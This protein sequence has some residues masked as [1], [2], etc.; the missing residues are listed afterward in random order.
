MVAENSYFVTSLECQADSRSAEGS[1]SVQAPALDGMI[2]HLLSGPVSLS[3]VAGLSGIAHRSNPQ[4]DQHG[5]ERNL[6]RP[7]AARA[8]IPRQSTGNI[9][10]TS[11][12]FIASIPHHH[13]AHLACLGAR[14]VKRRAAAAGVLP[15]PSAMPAR[16]PGKSKNAMFVLTGP[17]RLSGCQKQRYLSTSPHNCV[18]S[19]CPSLRSNTSRGRS[20]P[21]VHM[22][23]QALSK[24]HGPRPLAATSFRLACVSLL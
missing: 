4:P 15:R 2:A 13:R 17:N 23:P 18:P 22:R 3:T 11:A 5:Q 20:S 19:R 10:K 16:G 12:L 7:A 6:R 24:Q 1:A 14:F 9:T 8:A 21:A